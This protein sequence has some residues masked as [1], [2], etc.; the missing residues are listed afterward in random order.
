M[1]RIISEQYTVGGTDLFVHKY[2]GPKSPSDGDAT[3]GAPV[4][5]V[6]NETNIQDL[7]F[8]ENRDRKYDE[9]IY[10]LRGIYNV[11]DIDFDL[12]QFGLFLA[13]DN[14]FLTIHIRDSVKTIGRKIM[15]GD[16]LE[17]PHL[18]DEY[19]QNDF[20]IALKRFYV[21][22]DVSRGAEG[23]SQTWWPH[24][25]RLKLKQIFDSQEFK[26]ILDRPADEDN[27]SGITLRDLMSTFN[28]EKQIN[29][30]VL[31]QAETDSPKSG[32]STRHFYSLTE[33]KEGGTI[34][35]ID[36][37]EIPENFYDIDKT[38]LKFGYT[39]YLVVYGDG[40]PPN[41]Y[42]FGIGVSFPDLF[43]EGDY[44]LRTDYMP[45]RLFRFDGVKWTKMRDDLRMTLSN[46][47]DRQ[48]L[49]GSFINNNNVNTIA[50]EEF[51]ERQAL[52]KTLKPK[53]DN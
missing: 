44:F 16:V 17:L 34:T 20:S 18:K 2:L 48:T 31:L 9:H 40:T 35:R 4:Y 6:L 36:S 10:R 42:P 23:F 13:N 29:D 50:G 11:Q 14:I 32:W 38:P 7:L 15:S 39:G 5:E 8:L 41:G 37:S 24:I 52:S 53:A 21:V 22:E 45:N 47:D 25:Y 27:E 19:A 30:A 1:D 51:Q 26:D 12:S 28:K 3:P 49:K 33:L 43:E 46:T